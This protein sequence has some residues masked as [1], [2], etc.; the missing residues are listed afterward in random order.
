MSMAY[1]S[2]EEQVVRG[3][4]YLSLARYYNS[5]GAERSM[6]KKRKRR[7]KHESTPIDQSF[8]RPHN[9]S[10]TTTMLAEFIYG[11]HGQETLKRRPDSPERQMRNYNARVVEEFTILRRTTAQTIGGTASD[12]F[13]SFEF[14]KDAC[15]RYFW[16]YKL[17]ESSTHS[18]QHNDSA[19]EAYVSSVGLRRADTFT[20]DHG[21]ALLELV[22]LRYAIKLGLRVDLKHRGAGKPE[23]MRCYPVSLDARAQQLLLTVFE[24]DKNRYRLVHMID[25][26]SLN[27]DLWRMFAKNVPSPVPFSMAE[28][29]V[30]IR[31]DERR[32]TVIMPR[33]Y[34]AHFV[35]SLIA[36]VDIVSNTLQQVR[37]QLRGYSQS[38]MEQAM[39]PHL[40][41]V[42]I[43]P[44]TA[45]DQLFHSF[46]RQAK[47]LEE[48]A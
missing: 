8:A 21:D 35:R 36:P 25:V 9:G 24:A 15:S 17:R 33:E 7:R 11:L 14:Q 16:D 13:A 44:K 2:R 12:P 22:V 46:K 37:L 27:C 32:I 45:R 48:G 40:S 5:T 31:R 1:L 47:S 38:D 41:H 30:Q 23:Y 29:E 28:A 20:P 3:L 39:Y 34:Y 4:E 18:V 43:E 10:M 19:I 26:Q 42:Q 6:E